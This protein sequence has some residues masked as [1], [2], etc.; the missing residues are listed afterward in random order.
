MPALTSPTETVFTKATIGE[1]MTAFFRG[2]LTPTNMPA[3]RELYPDDFAYCYG[4]GRLNAH[5]LHVKSEWHEKES[6]A[7]FQPA[8]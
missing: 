1:S 6:I 8:P 5:G 2:P 3:P 4:Y 7:R